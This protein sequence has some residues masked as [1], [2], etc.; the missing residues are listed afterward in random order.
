MP[1]LTKHALVAAIAIC[2]LLAVSWTL[3]ATSPLAQET[4]EDSPGH[5]IAI[6]ANADWPASVLLI[7]N[8]ALAK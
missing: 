2:G 3:P 5:T 6:N 4:D 1:T 8:D 7:T